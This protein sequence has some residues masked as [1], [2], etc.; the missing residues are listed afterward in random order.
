MLLGRIHCGLEKTEGAHIHREDSM[1]SF[2]GVIN[3]AS[4]VDRS[5][6]NE[7]W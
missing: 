1:N 4:P 3:E 7:Y 2:V 5:I 6:G